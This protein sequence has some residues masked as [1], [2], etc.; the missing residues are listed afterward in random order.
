MESN[1]FFFLWKKAKE[2]KETSLLSCYYNRIVELLFSSHL[3][4]LSLL[5]SSLCPL[6]R[7][8]SRL[9]IFLPSLPLSSLTEKPGRNETEIRYG[10]TLVTT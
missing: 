2:G 10:G 9:L 8:S 3:L 5:S 4:S 6:P 1:T 7:L